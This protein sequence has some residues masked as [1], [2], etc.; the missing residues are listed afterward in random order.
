ME[1]FSKYKSCHEIDG[2]TKRARSLLVVVSTPPATIYEEF[3]DKVRK[4]NEMPPFHFKSGS[5]PNRTFMKFV[6]MH[7]AYL[8]D[9][10]KLY[11]LALHQLL[12]NEARPLTED[13]IRDVASNGTAIIYAIIQ[14]QTYLS[15]CCLA[16]FLDDISQ[17]IKLSKASLARKSKSIPMVTRK[18]TF[19][20]W[21]SKKL[22]FQSRIQISHVTDT[23]SSLHRF[24]KET[25]AI[26]Q[27][28]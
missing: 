16:S 24:I 1:E 6:S 28:Q 25:A 3:T 5:F 20:C 23:W 26:I 19:Q 7:A 22:R 27:F 21:R 9:S 11:A 17:L 15:K 12:M 14:N 13:V 18:E 10:V 8:Y 2:L 4:Y